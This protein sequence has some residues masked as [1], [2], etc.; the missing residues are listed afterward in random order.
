MM[1]TM[2]ASN[3]LSDDLF[4]LS[5]VELTRTR[6]ARPQLSRLADNRQRFTSSVSLPPG[7]PAGGLSFSLLAQPQ[8]A[9]ACSPPA[10]APAREQLP[11]V[12]ASLLSSWMG[13][14]TMRR[15]GA[16]WAAVVACVSARFSGQAAASPARPQRARP[17]A[18]HPSS[19]SQ[20]AQR[21][22][23]DAIERALLALCVSG[24]AE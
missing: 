16:G 8:C 15:A 17:L 18:Q 4:G 5:E 7:A 19:P 10:Y 12:H 6:E 9:S 21:D 20:R 23:L 2:R 13:K 11:A 3:C 22:S 1:T 24:S 14:V